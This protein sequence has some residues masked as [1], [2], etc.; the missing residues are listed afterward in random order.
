MNHEIHEAHEMG[1]VRQTRPNQIQRGGF[2]SRKV[3][4]VRKVSNS[5]TPSLPHSQLPTANR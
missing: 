4:E 3:R 1:A 2:V 5:L